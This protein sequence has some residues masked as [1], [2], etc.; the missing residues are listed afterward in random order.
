SLTRNI[1]INDTRRAITMEKNI[2]KISNL[3]SLLIHNTSQLIVML[4]TQHILAQLL[5]RHAAHVS[6]QAGKSALIHN[7][8]TVAEGEHFVQVRGYQK[9]GAALIPILQKPAPDKFCRA[10]VDAPGGL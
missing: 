9:N 4:Q 2:R 5:L 1:R 6:K 7:S 8:Q 3:F 10:H